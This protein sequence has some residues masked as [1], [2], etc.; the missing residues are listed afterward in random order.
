MTT[1]DKLIMLKS[2]LELSNNLR[3]QYLIQLLDVA[4]T[5]IEREGITLNESIADI[6]L[7]IMYAAY[8]YRSRNE[9]SVGIP[10]M[11][12]YALNNRL[13]SEKMGESS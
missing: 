11:L 3:N 1:D 6:N 13:L 9:D 7:V 5:E 12:R 2:N 8:L 10:R 4:E